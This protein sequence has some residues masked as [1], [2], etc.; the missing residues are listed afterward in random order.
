[1]LGEVERADDELSVLLTDDAFIRELN[2][3]HRGKD[4]P[5]D[6]LAFPLLP[7]GPGEPSAP[8]SA[9]LGDVVISLD[10]AARQARQRKHPLMAE[11]TFLLAHGILHLLGYDHETDEEEAQMNAMTIRLVAAAR[12]RPGRD[13]QPN[14]TQS[15]RT[16]RAPEPRKQGKTRHK[17]AAPRRTN[18]RVPRT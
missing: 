16:G 9:L 18:G 15:R 11:V 3:T 12:A 5:T 8:A 13:T 17:S 2:S 14:S 7:T 4:R 6:V 10:T 1:M